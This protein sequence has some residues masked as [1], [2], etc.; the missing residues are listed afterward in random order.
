MVSIS[1][2]VKGLSKFAKGKKISKVVKDGGDELV[3]PAPVKTVTSKEIEKGEKEM[4][5]PQVVRIL[6]REN[7]RESSQNSNSTNF[8]LT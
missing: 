2:C 5:Q 6:S 8:S 1:G 7:A 4:I 3:T